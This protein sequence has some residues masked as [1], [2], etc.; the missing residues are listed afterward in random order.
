[1][2]DSAA[3]VRKFHL[4]LNVSDLS[5][6]VAFYQ[7]LFGKP[8]A[9]HHADY[10]KF[11]VESPPAVVSLVPGR[12]GPAGA[13]NHVG[14][15]L[16][17]AEELVAIQV[18]LEE[19]GHKTLREDGVACCY[20]RQ[21]KFWVRDPDGVLLELYIF[22]EDMD[23][24]G[25]GH[26]PDH[27]LPT[28]MDGGSDPDAPVASWTH[29]LGEEVTL[30]LA[31]ETNSLQE[32]VLEGTF[33]MAPASLDLPAL[34]RDVLRALRPGGKVTLHG[35][36]ADRPL[37]GPCSSL[38]GPAA[39][40]QHV[41]DFPSLITQLQAAGFASARFTKLSEKGYFEAEGI[42]LRE[43]L[44]E[45]VKPG[46]RSSKK[47]QTVVYL[48][49]QSAVEDDFGNRYAKGCPTPVTMHDWLMLK[50]GSAGQ[51]TLLKRKAEAP[52]C[53]DACAEAG[54][55]SKEAMPTKA[56]YI[57]IGGFLG[58]GK[59]TTVG[60][61]AKYLTDQGLRVGLITND[62]AG[63]LVDTKLLRGQGYAT[64]EIAGGCF[65][66]RFN[67]LVEAANK[68]S[69]QAKPDVFIA[70]PVGS[71]TDLV[72]TVTYPLRRMYGDAFTVAPLSV[73]VDPVRARRVFG[74]DAG[75]SFSSK[76]AYIFKKQ[77]EEADI[78]VISKSDLLGE[79]AREELRAV[80]QK[81]FPVARIV[82]ASPREETGL[83]DL[84]S[85]LMTDEQARRNPMAVDYEVYADGEALLGWLN[86]TVTLK[87]TEEFEANDFLRALATNVQEQL[88]KEGTEIAHFKMTYSPD[89]G[90]AGEL[91]SINLVRSDY[92]PELGMELDEPSEGGQLIVNLRAEADPATLME[93]V[94]TGLEET[95]ASFPT[96]TAKLEHE[97]H[98]RPGKPTPTHRDE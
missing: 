60:R 88:Q 52:P 40:V 93:A 79:E 32:V 47:D 7:V 94:K 21:T 66:C 36:A 62:Q 73:L 1:M 59:T 8:A 22:H 46:F 29:Q 55:D 37:T 67:T 30:P 45:A 18:R 77:L 35:L 15:C 92:I 27:E 39:A 3:L 84:F 61:L 50:T 78:I 98:F 56:R 41:P 74:L 64:E 12:S 9:K 97:E 16:L 26:A 31:M 23:D 43:V 63:G 96:L 20:S 2:P 6:S 13:L 65:C 57:M 91:A 25:D 82:T 75:G 38:P 24:H 58:A 68:L 85:Q 90:I 86:A 44:I 72:A 83:T 89:D 70:E 54:I 17:D 76:V 49:P 11:E 42:P 80:L 87:A 71:C 10:A 51:F 28:G 81:E 14:L 69:D 5:K 34:L 19:A 33:N 53:G 95:T 48:G 4:S